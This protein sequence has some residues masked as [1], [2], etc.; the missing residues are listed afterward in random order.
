MLGVLNRLVACVLNR[1]VLNRQVGQAGFPEPH[2]PLAG[3]KRADAGIRASHS[4]RGSRRRGATSKQEDQ[5]GGA[6]S[7]SERSEEGTPTHHGDPG[8][9]LS[10]PR[11]QFPP[12]YIHLLAGHDHSLLG[13]ALYQLFEWTLAHL[14]NSGHGHKLLGYPRRLPV[15]I[16]SR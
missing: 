16:E 3:Q 1:L 12:R 10:C 9:G 4:E 2:E 15:R 14:V 11:G 5:R 13:R 6:G 7:R 8:A